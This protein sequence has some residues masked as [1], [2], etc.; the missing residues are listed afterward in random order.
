MGAPTATLINGEWVPDPTPAAKMSVT[1]YA[2]AGAQFVIARSGEA[3]SQVAL[4]TGVA[5]APAIYAQA[6]QAVL[7]GLAGDY[8]GA[9]TN[10]IPVIIAIGGIVAGF[11]TREQSNAKI[12]KTISTESR[13]ALLNDLD[14]LRSKLPAATHNP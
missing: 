8:I 6:G 9:A 1:D 13:D 11:I 10:G 3:S 14:G 4:G 5:L 7:L 12:E 2:K